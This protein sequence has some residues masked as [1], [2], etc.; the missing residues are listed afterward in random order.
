MLT[1]PFA[2]DEPGADA[3]PL[4]KK[5]GKIVWELKPDGD[6]TLLSVHSEFAPRTGRI[7]TAERVQLNLGQPLRVTGAV[8]E[9]TMTLIR[10]WLEEDWRELVSV[11]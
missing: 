2:A 8:R 5:K 9:L 10:L 1:D 3:G 4:D 7:Y 11:L 6:V